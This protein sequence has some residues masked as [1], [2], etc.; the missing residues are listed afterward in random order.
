MSVKNATFIDTQGCKTVVVYCLL[1]KTGVEGFD[2]SFN[3]TTKFS[4]PFEVRK[5]KTQFFSIFVLSLCLCLIFSFSLPLC[6]LLVLRSP[7]L[8]PNFSFQ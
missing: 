8:V 1:G 6:L 4:L 7:F 2:A 3:F 5:I